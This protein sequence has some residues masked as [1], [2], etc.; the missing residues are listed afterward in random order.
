[1]PLLSAVMDRI[2]NW[3]QQHRP[4]RVKTFQPGLSREEI[5][6]AIANLPN[7]FPEELYELYQW[8]N[9]STA[10]DAIDSL[11]SPILE[12]MPLE[13]AVKSCIDLLEV[14]GDDENLPDPILAG[15]KR[16]FPFICENSSCYYAV[17]LDNQQQQLSPVIDIGGEGD[18]DIVFDSL[19][20]MMQA[21]AGYCETGVYYI[22]DDGFLTC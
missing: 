19:T 11:V 2:L 12:F 20:D 5:D 6:Q 16:L 3:M 1:M 8:R 7:Q 13:E 22:N 4:E 21:L 18:L 15:G 9:G 14:F 10:W 17:F